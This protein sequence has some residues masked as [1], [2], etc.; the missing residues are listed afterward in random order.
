MDVK[1][2]QEDRCCWKCLHCFDEY[3]HYN[4]MRGAPITHDWE[5]FYCNEKHDY[6]NPHG[7]ETCFKPL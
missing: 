1:E 2:L 7:I 6:V 5:R 3:D 4:L